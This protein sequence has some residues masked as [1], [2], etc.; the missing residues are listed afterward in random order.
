MHPLH[1]LTPYV[2]NPAF[3]AFAALVASA[4]VRAMPTPLTGGSRFYLWFYG[5]LQLLMAN[6][7]KSTISISAV[8]ADTPQPVP[9]PA[10][11]HAP[12]LAVKS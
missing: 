1:N 12:G 5:F 10:P 9:A 8:P 2:W 11:A 6:L 4:A 7:D 3:G